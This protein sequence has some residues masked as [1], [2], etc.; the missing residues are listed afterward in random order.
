MGVEFK[1]LRGYNSAWRGADAKYRTENPQP[2]HAYGATPEAAAYQ[3]WYKG[4]NEAVKAASGDFP[5]L[6]GLDGCAS[7]PFAEWEKVT[8]GRWIVSR[9]YISGCGDEA[10][11]Y[12]CPL[13][14]EG[15]V[16]EPEIGWELWT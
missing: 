10:P 16:C 7:F 12:C 2:A 14:P 13:L 8:P 15:V 5:K 6:V 1:A 9:Y 11:Y 3:A 4:L